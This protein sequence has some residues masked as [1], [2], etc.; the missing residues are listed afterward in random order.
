MDKGN[1]WDYVAMYNFQQGNDAGG[2]I[3]AGFNLI[4]TKISDKLGDSSCSYSDDNFHHGE[5]VRQI[6]AGRGGLATF[7]CKCDYCGGTFTVTKTK[8]DLSAAYDD[9]V[10]TLPAPG[11]TSDGSLTY[12]PVH[13]YF[14]LHYS[15]GSAYGNVERY[16]EHYEGEDSGSGRFQFNF[17]C[18]SNSISVFPVSGASTFTSVYGSFHYKGTAP[19]DGYYTRLSTP[20]TTGYFL[21][22]DGVNNSLDADWDLQTSPTYYAAGATFSP[23]CSPPSF[24]G[25]YSSSRFAFIQGIPAVYE[26]TPASS[27]SADTYNIN[28]RPTSITGGNYGIIGDNGQITKVE[29]N[30]TIINETNNTYYNP[31][32]GTTV[33]ITNWSYD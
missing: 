33:P 10:E 11:Y 31:A 8:D 18:V 29:D 7:E 20:K 6:G 16:C 5:I 23:Y 3:G 25:Y 19:I 1:F 32:T 28:T 21:D 30:S 26:I 2:W 22:A 12:S 14:E 17:N 15:S 4:G 13:D 9:Y 24:S 27:L